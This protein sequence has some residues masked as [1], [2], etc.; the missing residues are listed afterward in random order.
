MSN[1]TSL[2][3]AIITQAIHYVFLI[4]SLF[5]YG[6]SGQGIGLGFLLWLISFIPEF[7]S[8]PLHIFGA[9]LNISRHHKLVPIIY[10]ILAILAIP[11]LIIIGTSSS[12]VD[13]IIWNTYYFILFLIPLSFNLK[14]HN[15]ISVTKHKNHKAHSPH[16]WA[17]SFLRVDFYRSLWYICNILFISLEWV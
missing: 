13:V 1:K 17:F 14:K 3:P 6:Y 5:D 9:A 15:W 7:F 8:I 16:E 2:R 10:L 12:T 11:L 4:L